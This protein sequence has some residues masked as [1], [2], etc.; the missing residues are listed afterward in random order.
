MILGMIQNEGLPL[1]P[2]TLK[3]SPRL[4]YYTPT[5]LNSHFCVSL[6]A[7]RSETLPNLPSLS[8]LFVLLFSASYIYIYFLRNCQAYADAP[9]PPS[10]LPPYHALVP[11][12]KVNEARRSPSPPQGAYPLQG[13]GYPQGGYPFQGGGGGHSPQGGSSQMSPQGVPRHISSPT[14]ASTRSSSPPHAGSPYQHDHRYEHQH[15]QSPPQG[16]QQQTPG[17]GRSPKARSIQTSP[18][19]QPFA[20]HGPSPQHQGELPRGQRSP[21]AAYAAAFHPRAPPAPYLPH[22]RSNIG[23]QQQRGRGSPSSS[24]PRS[25]SPRSPRS[26][27]SPHA[28]DHSYV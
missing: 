28:K 2:F 13:G 9:L 15:H 23:Q 27:R 26:P 19:P 12:D 25:Q 7:Q 5:C 20:H 4:F 10:P 22:A 6:Q 11:S 18:Q 3:Y 17:R 8:F 14:D 21:T 1:Q 24:S 16:Q